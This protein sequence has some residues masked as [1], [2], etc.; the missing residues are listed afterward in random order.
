MNLEVA[1]ARAR[2]IARRDTA[3]FK[4]AV[5]QLIDAGMGGRAAV[6]F[7]LDARRAK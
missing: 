2:L 3:A 4:R 5:I 6:K 1:Q 7:A